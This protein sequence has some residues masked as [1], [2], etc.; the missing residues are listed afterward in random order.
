MG[1]QLKP[2]RRKITSLNTSDDVLVEGDLIVEGTITSGAFSLP[3]DT[4]VAGN[5]EVDL[6]LTV[7]GNATVVGDLAV[8]GD[9]TFTGSILGVGALTA[10]DDI[11]ISSAASPKFQVT[12][13][14]NT[15]VGFLKSDDTK[16][17]LG[18]SSN[19]GIELH[20]N[21]T[22][23]L[24]IS[25]AGASTFAGSVSM[26][27]AASPTLT[28]TDS[29]NGVA[30][31]ALSNDT[32]SSVGTSSN[33]PLDILTNNLARI[34]VAAAGTVTVFGTLQ[35]GAA[36]GES[37]NLKASMTS[38]TCNSGTATQTITGAIPAGAKVH[39]V[40]ARVTTILAGAGLTTWKLGDTG[41]DDR[42][43]AALALAAGTTVNHTNATANPEGT[44]ASTAR[45]LTI[46]ATAG[47]FDSGVVRVTVFYEDCTAPTS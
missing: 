6:N 12:D 46:K 39:F 9:T 19:H 7:D 36:N 21:G 8:Q 14:T 26:T 28:I 24:T 42:Y 20:T 17:S 43:G 44:W 47:Q 29:T 11:L 3:D 37:V 40:V 34:T 4:E 31:V 23:R 30:L 1:L 41:D 18:A 45:D 10:A 33:H 27:A 38:T 2:K 5:F 25:N 16:V 35:K 32:Q 15:V 13:T 22:A